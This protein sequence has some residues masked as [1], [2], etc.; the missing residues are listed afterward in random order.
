MQLS[1]SSEQLMRLL[2]CIDIHIS[3][4]NA[5]TSGDAH[6]HSMEEMPTD[7]TLS[8]ALAEAIGP[9]VQEGRHVFL[10]GATLLKIARKLMHM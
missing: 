7:A 9:C 3:L 1:K 6:G 10:S 2:V 8:P 5:W 4:E